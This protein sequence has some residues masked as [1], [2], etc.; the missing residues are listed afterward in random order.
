MSGKGRIWSWTTTHRSVITNFD[1]V[2][3]YTCIVVELEEQAGLFLV[4]DLVGR[5]LGAELKVG[6]PVSVFFA[7]LG[8]KGKVLPQF[9]L[10]Q[11]RE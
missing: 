8:E 9:K 2:L 3:P 1:Q 5:E 6:L 7:P 11:D 10:D 4:S